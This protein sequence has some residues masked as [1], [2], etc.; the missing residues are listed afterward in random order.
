MTRLGALFSAV[1]VPSL[2][3]HLGET[4]IHYPMGEASA[5]TE[6]TGAIVDWSDEEGRTR[7]ET[8]QQSGEQIDRYCL[9]DLPVSV[10]VTCNERSDRRDQFGITDPVSGDEELVTAMRI[11]GRDTAMQTIVCHRVDKI[12]TKRTRVKP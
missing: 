3:S 8:I 7:T 11:V 5:A 6:I 2:R 1:G 4:I 9:I 10:R 12:T